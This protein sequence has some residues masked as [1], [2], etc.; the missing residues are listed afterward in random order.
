M[1]FEAITRVSGM[2]DDEIATLNV[3]LKQLDDK[4]DRNLLRASIYDGKRA[5]RQ[6]S[7]VVPPQYH[8]MGIV[9]G[10][11]AKGVDGLARRC[12]LEKFTW[13]D[14]DLASI[15]GQTVWDDNLLRSELNA[16]T[17]SSLIH[18]S[19]FL[20]NLAGE[21]DK[22]E[23]KSLIISKDALNATG[24]WNIRRRAMDNLV[25][26]N[27]RKDDK[28]TEVVLYL[29]GVTI[30][31]EQNEKGRWA[32]TRSEHS[33]GVP[34]EPLV[35]RRR[36]GRAFGSSRITRAAIGIQ[37]AAVRDLIRLEGHMDIYAYPELIL[38][39]ADGSVFK[40]E[41][42]NTLSAWQVMLGRIKGIPDDEE[43][44]QPRA[45]VKHIP[46]A[47]P[48][49]HLASLNTRAR[50]MAREMNLP[51][52]ALAI[53]DIANPTSGDSYDASQYELIADAEA[54]IDDWAPA[55]RRS[56]LRALAILNGETE[57]PDAW[58]TIDSKFRDPRF[59]S[60][61]AAADAGSKAIGSAPWLAETEVGL[62]LLG[63]DDQQITRALAEKRR[64]GGSAA[65][66]AIADAAAA[67]KPVVTANAPVSDS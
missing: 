12:T 8:R 19:S 1:T 65:L 17:T 38:L 57:I 29:D 61:A 58:K 46:A 63:L 33:W 5:L 56:Y 62:E 24:E 67:G 54:A 64:L 45:D 11:A 21:P 30:S 59:T 60:R 43:A 35:Y 14:G 66:R 44:T 3:L 37:D 41:A 49:P 4:R 40:D 9:L 47:S 25:S 16:A 26:V 7:R 20:I 15:G 13:A 50:L 52:T 39:G 28:P 6:I 32:A 18:A 55:L 2:N 36:T 53:S 22:R 34:V 51:D 31:I 42:G 23:P 27:A 48:Q 10:W